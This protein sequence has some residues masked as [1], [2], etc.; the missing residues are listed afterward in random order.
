MI[1]PAPK[2]TFRKSRLVLALIFFSMVTVF[3]AKADDGDDGKRDYNTPAVDFYLEHLATYAGAVADPTDPS[4]AGTSCANAY[5]RLYAKDTLRIRVFLGYLDYGAQKW[6]PENDRVFDPLIQK[7]VAEVLQRPC[8]Q[9]MYACGFKPEKEFVLTKPVT[10][11]DGTPR[12][13]EV[14]IE[15]SAASDSYEANQKE[16]RKPQKEKSRQTMQDFAQSLRDGSQVVLYYG[17]S[18]GYFEK[19]GT[20]PG[21]GPLPRYHLGWWEAGFFE[22]SK[23]KML[24][25]LSSSEDR[26]TLVGYYGCFTDQYYRKGFLK[27]DSDLAL[28]LTDGQMRD[29]DDLSV[30]LGT[31]NALAG[32]QCQDDFERA[33]GKDKLTGFFRP[34]P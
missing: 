6:T 4:S 12:T 11:P 2:R 33:L 14:T 15:N 24:G 16:L 19:Y 28:I 8:S 27:A 25:V 29:S 10:A 30:M 18:R 32:K 17:H 20:G 26:P 31:V 21:F 34:A 22:P 3:S 13:I 9:H 1:G 5:N 7:Y 23:R